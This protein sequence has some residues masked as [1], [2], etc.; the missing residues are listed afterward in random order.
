[1]QEQKIETSDAT[2]GIECK[3]EKH[4]NSQNRIR[5]KSSFANIG[6]MIVALTLSEHSNYLQQIQQVDEYTE[7]INQLQQEIDSNDIKAMQKQLAVYEKQV[8]KLS[9]S[10]NSYKQWNSEF[11]TT[12]ED[13]EQTIAELKEMNDKLAKEKDNLETQLDNSIDA[14]EI[15]DLQETIATLKDKLNG[16]ENNAKYWQNSYNGMIDSSDELANRNESLIA[17]NEKLRNDYNAINETNKL[18]NENLIA[19]NNTFN[20]TK[21]ELQL[22]FQ[23]KEN[24]LKET[25]KNQQ[26]HI[27]ELTEKYQSL[28]VLKEH[29]PAK[30]HYDEILGL[31]QKIK[32]KE[33]E[34]AK[35]NG[36]IEVKL[37]TQKNELNS[38]HSNEKA[39]MLVAYNKELDNL[40]LQYNNLANDYNNLISDLY[41][42]TKWNAIFDSRHE[43]IRNN[44]EPIQLL[45]I[46]S[47]QLPPADEKVI[48]F[49]P[50]D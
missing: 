27:D 46:P 30:T 10:N 49:I 39:Q 16:A 23:N 25:I 22:D 19:S 13:L 21:Q 33:N 8:D 32:D 12:I 11:K 28:L 17:E 43:K 44:K 26:S 31:Q 6:D 24:E 42:I 41:T 37:A 50:K 7:K 36:D 45:E 29:I 3:V 47:E 18:L 1:M 48:E 4:N 40:K 34:I 20:E 14:S 35:L 9:K 38:E 5:F 15:E 2:I